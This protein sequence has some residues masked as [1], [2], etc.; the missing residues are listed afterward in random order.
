M[1]IAV[2]PRVR[3]TYVTEVT[4]GT[5]PGTPSMKV[6]RCID[7]DINLQKNTLESEEVHS[8]RQVQ[9]LRHGFN[10]I[11]SSVSGE[12]GIGVL[13]DWL[14]SAV[15]G[16]WATNVL[17][18]GT[19][20]KTFTVERQ[21]LDLAQYEVSKGISVNTL[22]LRIQ[23]ESIVGWTAGLLGMSAVA[24]SGTPLD[25][26]PDAAA[27]R[28]PFDTFIGSIT[29][30]GGAI[31]TV[32]GLTIN[33]D[34]GRALSP[35]VGS[36]YSPDVFEG[37]FRVTGTISAFFESATLA[38]KF[39]NETESEAVVVLNDLAG[40]DSLTID[41]PRIKYTGNNKNPPRVGGVIQNMPFQA[42]YST[43]DAASIIFTRTAS[44]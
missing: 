17:K 31:A 12:L 36:K 18:P 25:A 37:V 26:S 42:L 32:T 20:M 30:G 16:A 15:S 29:E 19:T 33:L 3:L 8:H 43:G 27:T 35:V 4:R 23:P 44:S 11:D 21:F 10:F 40:V 28:A 1:A 39:L 14:E 2:G 34:N 6:L 13:D 9:D 24:A 38:N 41:L 7:R 22:E 5:T